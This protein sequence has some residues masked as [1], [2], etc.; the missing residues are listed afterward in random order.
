MILPNIKNIENVINK[1]KEIDLK[2]EKA[3]D[4][5]NELI[6][7]GFQ[8]LPIPVYIMP[9]N[10][11]FC[12][13]RRN[14]DI[15]RFNEVQQLWHREDIENI[16]S[17]GRA[18]EPQQSVFYCSEIRP[19]ALCETSEAI[20]GDT[21][22]EKEVITTGLWELK[23]NIRLAAVVHTDK[24][25][26][27]NDLT[28]FHGRN[29]DNLTDIQF[30]G[31]IIKVNKI[32]NFFSD[33]FAKYVDDGNDYEYKI[34]CAFSNFAYRTCDGIFYP[35]VRFNYEG[36]NYAFKPDIM[37]GK[38]LVLL[39]ACEDTFIRNGEKSY[40]NTIHINT[41]NVDYGTMKLMW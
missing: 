13:C 25:R 33:E 30:P 38:K 26:E 27:K 1:L 41:K 29:F 34:S 9:K 2:S 17:F 31:E 24:T 4:N 19:T 7:K 39:E 20:R 32:L 14:K 35:S 36:M 8:R 22:I 3:Y 28:N 40:K 37:I 23:D 16:R 10:V 18:N 5:I 15:P 11:R 12:R 21:S 6:E